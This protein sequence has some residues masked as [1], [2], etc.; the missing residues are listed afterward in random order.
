MQACVIIQLKYPQKQAHWVQSPHVRV[1]ALAGKYQRIV[2][3][4]VLL[5]S[6]FV[7]ISIPLSKSVLNIH[8]LGADL[9]QSRLNLPI[10]LRIPNSEVD[11]K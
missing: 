3:A 2:A 9:M 6:L 7:L 1:R 4:C 10:V 8:L 11:L 5:C